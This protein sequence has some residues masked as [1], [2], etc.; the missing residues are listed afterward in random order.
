VGETAT[1]IVGAWQAGAIRRDTITD[2]FRRSEVLPEGRSREEEEKLIG[3]DAKPAAAKL[4]VG[5]VNGQK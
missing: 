5:G 2:L 4:K 1:A 3:Q